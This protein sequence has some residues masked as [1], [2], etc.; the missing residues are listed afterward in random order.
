MAFADFGDTAGLKLVKN[1]PVR[2][3]DLLGRYS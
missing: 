2:V 1:L 3:R